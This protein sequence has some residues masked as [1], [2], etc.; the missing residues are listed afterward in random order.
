M[1]SISCLELNVSETCNYK[2]EYCI[3]ERNAMEEGIMDPDRAVEYALMYD[4]YLNHV[5]RTNEGMIYFGAGEPLINWKAIEAVTDALG[6]TKSKVKLN[7]MTNASL[8]TKDMLIFARD[9]NIN[10]GFSIDGGSNKQKMTRIP[11]DERID[12]YKVVID[13]LENSREIGYQ[14]YSLS[15]TYNAVDFVEEALNVID[16]CIKYHI[17]E[18]DLDYDIEALNDTEINRVCEQLI[19]CYSV[20]KSKGLNVFGYWLIPVLNKLNEGSGDNCYCPNAVGKS[21][22]ISAN[23]KLKVCG[24]D[25]SSFNDFVDFDTIDINKEYVHYLEMSNKYVNDCQTCELCDLCKG[26]CIFN[27]KGTE[28]WKLNCVLMKKIYHILIDTRFT[29]YHISKNVITIPVN[30]DLVIC[31]NRIL[32]CPLIIDKEAET[33]ISAHTQINV[34]ESASFSEEELKLMSSCLGSYIYTIYDDYEIDLVREQNL[35]HM[36]KVKEGQVF[37]SL[38][39]RVCEK[40]N[41]GCKHCIA[42]EA[43]DSKMMDIYSAIK[44]IDA[45]IC[46]KKLDKKEEDEIEVHFGNCEPLINFDTIRQAVLYIKEKY[47]YLTAKYSINSNLSLLNREMADFF[48]DNSFEVYVSL[49]GLKESNDR[50]RIFK[51]GRGTFDVIMD[52]LRLLESAG[53]KIEGISVTITEEN[54]KFFDDRFVDWCETMGFISVGCDFDLIHSLSISN[55]SKVEFLTDYWKR[56]TKKGIEFFGTWITPF[57]ILSNNSITYGADGFCKAVTGQNFSV[58]ANGRIFVCDYSSKYL[59]DI[60]NIKAS[61]SPDGKY[62]NF[63]RSNLIGETEPFSGC[64]DCEIYGACGGQCMMT[65]T[66]GDSKKVMEQCDFYRRITMEMLKIKAAMMTS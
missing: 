6:K 20:A 8:L 40:C 36:K 7:L 50:I 32:N 35:L 12:S 26:Q 38:S 55:E 63:V 25:V 59:A 41:F 15:A 52:K 31:Y 54:F 46:L 3:F 30:D 19:F 5:G 66:S 29:T 58:D 43:K 53:K 56:F 49:D 61:I 10:I 60:D 28:Q 18:F 23:G 45:Y 62:Y 34:S 9:N 27:K 21:V 42:D 17:D 57:L 24:Y 16:L 64:K 4:A 11:R 14:V 1:K 51:D 37:S 22:C 33:W 13:A 2:C 47:P 48:I 65:R 44:A 39:L